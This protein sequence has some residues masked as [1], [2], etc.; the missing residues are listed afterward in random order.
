M[1]HF[2]DKL[3]YHNNNT[4]KTKYRTVNTVLM[5]TDNKFQHLNKNEIQKLKKELTLK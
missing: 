5:E 1:T 3:N 2:G 4:M